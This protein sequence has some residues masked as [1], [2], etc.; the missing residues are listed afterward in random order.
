MTV[1]SSGVERLLILKREE[2][3]TLFFCLNRHDEKWHEEASGRPHR[4]GKLVREGKFLNDARLEAIPFVADRSGFCCEVPFSR[5]HSI[6]RHNVP[7]FAFHTPS[8]ES[9]Q[10]DSLEC[11]A[12]GLTEVEINLCKIYFYLAGNL[13]GFGESQNEKHKNN[14]ILSEAIFCWP[15]SFSAV[16]SVL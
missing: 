2:F 12:L 5:R 9:K 13:D 3:L 10:R 14:F 15:G 8:G 1:P 4:D 6:K 16:Y 11:F 7:R